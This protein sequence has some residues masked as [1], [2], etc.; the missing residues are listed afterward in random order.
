MENL[1]AKLNILSQ[2]ITVMTRIPCT[3]LAS[4]CFHSNSQTNRVYIGNISL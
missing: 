3:L 2:R 4:Q 1:F